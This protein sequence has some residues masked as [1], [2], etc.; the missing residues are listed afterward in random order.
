VERVVK[1][2]SDPQ[3]IELA[4]SAARPSE[5]EEIIGEVFLPCFPEDGE[6]VGTAAAS[7]DE[8]PSGVP[9]IYFKMPSGNIIC[10]VSREAAVCEILDRRYTP[11]IPRPFSCQLDYGS[12]LSVGPQGPA[13]FDCYGDSMKG[14]AD[15]KLAYGYEISEGPM[16][17]LSEESGVTCENRAGTG[18]FLSV[19]QAQL[20]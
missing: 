10:A 9:T 8:S 15:E 20:F 14:I 6:E 2:L 7:E 5:Q 4:N 19:Q 13:Q 18:F 16:R 1:E 3:L 17:C 12:R 11:E